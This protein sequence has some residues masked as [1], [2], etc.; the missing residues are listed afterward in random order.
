MATIDVASNSALL[1]VAE[2]LAEQN[3]ILTNGSVTI[4]GDDGISASHSW[5][6]TVLT[7]TSASGTSSADLKGDQGIQGIPGETGNS[8]VYVGAGEMPDDCNVQIDPDGDIIDLAAIKA[9]VTPVKGVD[10]FD[11]NDYVLTPADMQDI[12]EMVDGATIVQA[13]KYVNSVDEM[14]DTSRVYVLASTGKIWAYMNATVEKEVTRRVDIVGTTDN[15]YIANSRLTSSSTEDTF[16]NDASGYVVTPKIDLTKE[17]YQGKTII[18]H[19]EGLEYFTETATTWI[20]HRDY[21][22]DGSIIQGR[23]SSD[24]PMSG[25]NTFYSCQNIIITRHSASNTALEITPPIKY[26]SEAVEIGYVR[27]CAQ[28]TESASTIYITYPDTEIVT[29]G[30]WVDTGTA[31]APTLTNEEK[32]E[33]AEQAAAIIDNNLLSVIGSGEVSV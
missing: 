29:G 32:A 12:A 15:P 25:G 22:Y 28:G 16:S 31:Y 27:F 17:A 10:Y 11:G 8:G 24:C 20:Q 7:I 18:L 30:A 9:E 2:K 6:G 3:N 1:A 14:T 4:R 26:G 13:P 33:I 19:L 23:S 5:D 21:R